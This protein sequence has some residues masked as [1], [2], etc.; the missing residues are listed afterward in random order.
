MV[1]SAIK[2]KDHCIN[3]DSRVDQNARISGF[4]NTNNNLIKSEANHG[5]TWLNQKV[6][7]SDPDF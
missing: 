7:A 3:K 1:A 5:L 6:S 2:L 4:Q